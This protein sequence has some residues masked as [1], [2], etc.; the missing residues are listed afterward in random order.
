MKKFLPKSL[1][2]ILELF[3]SNNKMLYL[4][5]GCVRDYIINPNEYSPKDFDLCTD[6]FPDEISKIIGNKYKYS[7]HGE[8]FNV[9]KVY[10]KDY[11]EGY[12]IATFR[13]DVYDGKIGKTRNPDIVYSD[14]KG[15]SERRDFTMNAIYYDLSTDNFIDYHNGISDIKSGI[16]RFVGNPYERLKEDP[17]RALRAIRFKLQYG[18]NFEKDVDEALKNVDL[19]YISRERIFDN[20]IGELVKSYNKIDDKKLLFIELNK[21]LLVSKILYHRKK[22][23]IIIDCSSLEI[24]LYKNIDF[25]NYTI[26][27]YYVVLALKVDRDIAKK[28]AFLYKLRG[29]DICEENIRSFIKNISLFSIKESELIE[30]GF[31]KNLAKKLTT[32]KLSIKPLENIS[33]YEQGKY[34]NKMEYEIFKSS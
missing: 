21:Y 20:N 33:N 13:S 24:F 3:L 1:Y 7:I 31:D 22:R 15:D 34:L 16:I 11:P 23:D 12:E 8:A 4:V 2:N 10:T 9:V 32:F 18:F 14:I 27:P 5:G 26:D 25:E 29:N 17:L 19:S 28:V 6:A 30:I